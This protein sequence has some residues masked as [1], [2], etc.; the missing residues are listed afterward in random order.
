M[1]NTISNNSIVDIGVSDINAK[2]DSDSVN[3]NKTEQAVIK[4]IE[5]TEEQSQPKADVSVEQLEVVAQKLQE[6]VGKM[7]K[8]LEFLVDQDSGRDVIKVIDK[9]NGDLIK[10]YPSEE[11]LDL[12]TKLSEATGSLF[13]EQV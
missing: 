7:N 9:T 5:V 11:V 6:F 10:Q 4:D 3:S 12:V 13:N 1:M 2:N 8:G